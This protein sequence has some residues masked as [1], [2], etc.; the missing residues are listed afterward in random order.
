MLLE[1]LARVAVHCEMFGANF[2][3]YWSLCDAFPLSISTRALD[4]MRL[5]SRECEK[6]NIAPLRQTSTLPPLRFSVSGFKYIVRLE[7]SKR[8]ADP[9]SSRF[10]R[11][12]FRSEGTRRAP[13][14]C[15]ALPQAVARPTRPPARPPRSGRLSD[16]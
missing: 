5:S 15:P 12:F 7:S 8:G 16:T 4:R 14:G 10:V 3:W 13:G 9:R 2:Y 11:P 1:G 6:A